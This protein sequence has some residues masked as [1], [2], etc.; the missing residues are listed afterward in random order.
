MNESR[1]YCAGQGL[2]SCRALNTWYECRSLA[3]G[4]CG[5]CVNYF[6]NDVS[7]KYRDK[8]KHSRLAWPASYVDMAIQPNQTNA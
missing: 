4:F 2:G 7:A 6:P 1:T 3:R 8:N 5:A